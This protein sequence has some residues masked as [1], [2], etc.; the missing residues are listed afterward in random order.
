MEEAMEEAME[1]LETAEEVGDIVE[2]VVIHETSD[3]AG[4]LQQMS[5]AFMVR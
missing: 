2:V 5:W 4:Q 3:S 1:A